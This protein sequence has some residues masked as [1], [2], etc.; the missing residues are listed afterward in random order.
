MPT[1]FT[2][3]YQVY[4]KKMRDE[5]KAENPEAD[6]KEIYILLATAWNNLDDDA[7]QE[8]KVI[9]KEENLRILEKE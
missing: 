1:K 9:A 5:I 3:G 2:N 8:Y 7:K 4:C 6:K